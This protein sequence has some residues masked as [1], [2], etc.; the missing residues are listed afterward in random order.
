MAGTV[1]SLQ[2]FA[3]VVLVLLSAVAAV[4]QIRFRNVASEAGLD[5][6]LESGPT[7]LKPMIEAVAGG[8]AAFDANGDG[9]TD[10]FS[11]MVPTPGHSRRVGGVIGTAYIGT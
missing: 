9:L 5:F 4:G 11:R 7:P 1:W 10:I 2:C 8:V 6:V 3:A